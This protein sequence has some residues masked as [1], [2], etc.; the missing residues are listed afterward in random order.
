MRNLKYGQ[1]HGL[2]GVD[3]TAVYKDIQGLVAQRKAVAQNNEYTKAPQP[4]NLGL[5]TTN[6][7]SLNQRSK[8]HPKKST[9]NKKVHL[10]KFF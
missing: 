8:I 3:E 6:Q 10:N 5:V 9:Q 7:S 4:Q 2:S 1:Q